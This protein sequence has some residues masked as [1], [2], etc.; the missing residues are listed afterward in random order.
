MSFRRLFPLAGS[1]G[2]VEPHRAAEVSVLKIWCT[3]IA[4]LSAR[5]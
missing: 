4:L 3:G 2:R 1:P 5:S